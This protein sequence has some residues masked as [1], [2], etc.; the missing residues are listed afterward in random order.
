MIGSA[1]I[2]IIYC[3]RFQLETVTLVELV[4]RSTS[5]RDD[6]TVAYRRS[7]QNDGLAIDQRIGWHR[8]A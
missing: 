5:K 1:I 6:Y 4:A 2:Y 3:G 8:A 7:F